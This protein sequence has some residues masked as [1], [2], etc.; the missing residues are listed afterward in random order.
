MNK[1]IPKIS[2]PLLTGSEA[3]LFAPIS[4]APMV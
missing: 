2:I 4:L 1:S 3:A